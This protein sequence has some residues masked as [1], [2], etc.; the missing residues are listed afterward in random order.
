M[1]GLRGLFFL[2]IVI[3]FGMVFFKVLS[4]QLFAFKKVNIVFDPFCAETLQH[5]VKNYLDTT[6]LKKCAPAL[7]KDI[8]Q[9]F[10]IAKDITYWQKNGNQYLLCINVYQPLYIINQNYIML[11]SGLITKK[12]YFVHESTNS[13]YHL[14]V[15][16]ENEGVSESLTNWLAESSDELFDLFTIHLINP[17]E[18]L[19]T[20]KH[21]KQFT[22]RCHYTCRF[23]DELLTRCLALKNEV[24]VLEPTK[25]GLGNCWVADLRFSKQIIL[26]KRGNN[27]GK[28]VL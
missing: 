15:A 18:I 17:T 6:M 16:Q 1:K 8:K 13:L 20:D 27:E 22:I 4:E 21:M 3:A 23:T 7:C 26:Y 10:P 19:L 5:E 12:D 11:E 25:K 2:S 24:A 28:N 9:H 14:S